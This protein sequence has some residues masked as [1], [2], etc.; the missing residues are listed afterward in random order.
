M[1]QSKITK[2]YPLFEAYGAL[3]DKGFY[4]F[5]LNSI[6]NKNQSDFSCMKVANIG[7]YNDILAGKL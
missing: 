7:V 1:S 4:N 6:N 2:E 5:G 3:G